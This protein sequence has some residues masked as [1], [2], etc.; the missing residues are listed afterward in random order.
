MGVVVQFML[1]QQPRRIAVGTE[2][3]PYLIAGQAVVTLH[4]A[5]LVELAC[6]QDVNRLIRPGTTT[7]NRVAVL[8]VKIDVQARADYLR[9]TVAFRCLNKRLVRRSILADLTAGGQGVNAS[10]CAGQSGG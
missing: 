2:T 9:R 6:G 8:T 10:A 4:Q 7:S 3:T 1:E 5:L